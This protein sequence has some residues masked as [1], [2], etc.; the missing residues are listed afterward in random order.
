MRNTYRPG[1]IEYDIS[2]LNYNGEFANIKKIV[3][4]FN[5]YEDIFSNVLKADFL[6][7]DALGLPETL[8][9]V[10]D[11]IIQVEFRTD[12]SLE[13]V[14]LKFRTYKLDKRVI[15]E[16]RQHIYALYAVSEEMYDSILTFADNHF[17]GQT[18]DGITRSIFGEYLSNGGKNLETESAINKITTTSAGHHPFEYINMI[19]KEAQSDQ[20]TDSSYYIFYEDHKGFK[21]K[22]I[23]QLLNA[24]PVE[25]YYLADPTAGEDVESDRSDLRRYQIIS[26]LSFNSSFDIMK[27]L[28]GGMMDTTV[29]YIDPIMKKYEESTFKYLSDFNKLSNMPGG[30]AILPASGKFATTEG[31]GHMRMVA[32][33]WND[34]STQTF[35]DRI[36]ESTDPHK[37]HSSKRWK[38]YHNGVAL[39]QSL[40]QYGI[41]ITVPGNSEIKCG[42]CINI[43]IPQNSPVTTDAARYLKL[44]GQRQPKFL[45]T[46]VL[47]NYKQTTGEYYTTIQG[48]KQSFGKEPTAEA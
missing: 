19:A 26:A 34:E 25:D 44:Y 35:D 13:R 18:P 40:H 38:Y 27:G 45:V 10:G 1:V 29:G 46:A 6:I 37:F 3:A 42:D 41:N 47:H 11:E 4:E 43:F 16:E 36:N 28:T 17:V 48:V 32:T 14:K 39:L 22:T 7:D 31:T 23:N 21:F 33:D 24:D 8:P 12:Q 30:R 5:I 9:I 15:S 20:Y 2:I